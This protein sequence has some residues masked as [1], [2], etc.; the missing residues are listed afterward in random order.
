M[1]DVVVF[2]RVSKAFH[3]QRMRSR[4]F[5]EVLV[6]FGR[7]QHAPAYDQLD[8]L[9]AVSFT[10][11]HGA[12]VGFIG[13]NGAGKSTVLKLIA[14]IMDPDAGS[15]T[16]NGRV[17]ALLELGAGFHPDL[18]GRD[19]I[20]LNGSIMGLSRRDVS[21]RFDEMVAFA[22]LERFVDVPVKHYSSGMYVRLG[23]A[24]AVHTDPEILLVDE[25]LAVGDAAF[26]RKCFERIDRLRQ[27]GVTLLFVSHSADA[28]RRLCSRVIW[29]DSGT[30]MADG[31]ADSVVQRYAAH[32]W[33]AE[34]GRLRAASDRR[35]GSGRVQIVSV[36]LLGRDGTEKQI[37]EFGEPMT[38]ILHYQAAERVQQPIFG[39]AIHRSDGTHITGPN[40]QFQ[41]LDL[42]WVEGEGLIRYTVDA[43]PLMEGTYAISVA[44]TDAADTEIYDYHDRL[45]PFQM[46][47]VEG[48]ERYGLVTLGGRWARGGY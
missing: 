34:E 21:R 46:R 26:Q 37:F 31:T 14:H 24:V 30:V 7:P 20:Y 12:T 39:L 11:E 9:D 42:G 2:D 47:P 40:T 8:A 45:Y 33:K 5:Q 27:E 36:H 16:V 25:V 43:L 4:S 6:N 18:S 48:K 1:N 38:V 17:G 19:N 41:G 23:F 44:A 35:W 22:E 15:V 29:L 28:V 13:P 32:G 10:I 3:L